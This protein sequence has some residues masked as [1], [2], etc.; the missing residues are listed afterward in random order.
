MNAVE[1]KV[2]EV[3]KPEVLFNEQEISN[4]LTGVLEAYD[5]LVFTDETVKDCKA[6]VTE[7][8]KM[9]KS[10]DKFRLDYK[11]ELSE[12]ITE[13]EKKCKRIMQQIEDV[14][15]PLKLQ[16]DN[17][18]IKRRAERKAEVEGFI[19]EALSIVSLEQ[20]WIDK[21]EF[22]DEWLNSSMTNPKVKKAIMDDIQLLLLD[23]KSYYDKREIVN[24]KC[25]NYSYKFG[26]SV[27]LLPDN[28]YHLCDNHDGPTI[29]AR[30]YEIAEKTAEREKEAIERIKREA[31]QQA[32]ANAQVEIDRVKQESAIKVTEA[33]EVAAAVTEQIE[34]FIPVEEEKAQMYTATYKVRG[35]KN[36]LMALTEYMASIGIEVTKL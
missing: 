15:A 23:Q 8:N 16:A 12:P 30:I 33:L 32:Q 3:K 7:L 10:V 34:K 20:R 14:Q 1:L 36:Q 5:G 35:T 6:T 31:E 26:L 21:S 17:F 19:A 13:F 25:E 18:E 2:L 27:P 4:Y 24:T 11:K 9:I 29:D 28:F 22:K